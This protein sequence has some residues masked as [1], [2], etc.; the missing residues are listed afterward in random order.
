MRID[1]LESKVARWIDD[2][3]DTLNKEE[4]LDYEY[5]R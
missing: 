4:T 3:A 1:E 5:R 2:L